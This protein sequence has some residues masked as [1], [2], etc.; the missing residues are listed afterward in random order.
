LAGFLKEGGPSKDPTLI[1]NI[2]VENPPH[3]TSG[4]EDVNWQKRE[5][6]IR[7]DSSEDTC[8]WQK[9]RRNRRTSR[10]NE[11][12]RTGCEAGQSRTRS[13]LK[14]LFGDYATLFVIFFLPNEGGSHTMSS[15]LRAWNRG[16]IEMMHVKTMN[17]Q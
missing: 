16:A 4:G 11:F 9:P 7:G 17:N 14:P 5:P 10:P 2:V 3:A 8:G 13:D 12:R 6:S 1:Q 15:R